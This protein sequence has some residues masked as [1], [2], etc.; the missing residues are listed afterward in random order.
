MRVWCKALYCDKTR[1][2]V[3]A[4]SAQRGS[5]QVGVCTELCESLK[6]EP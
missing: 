5:A 4:T 1:H 2:V 3:K 6:S